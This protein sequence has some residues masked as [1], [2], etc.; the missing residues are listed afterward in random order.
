LAVGPDCC[1]PVTSAIVV[2]GRTESLLVT[3]GTVPE[4]AP[5]H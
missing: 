1:S 2:A 3:V 5:T 4:T